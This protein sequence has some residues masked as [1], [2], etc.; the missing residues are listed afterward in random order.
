MMVIYILVFIFLR[1]E[2]SWLV[3]PFSLLEKL[4]PSPN[5]TMHIQGL[6]WLV[7]ATA[8]PQVQFC[9]CVWQVKRGQS[10]KLHGT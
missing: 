2:G 6:A 4:P 5:T 8:S 10:H 9:V 7:D 1:T 3:I